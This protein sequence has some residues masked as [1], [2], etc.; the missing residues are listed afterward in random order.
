MEHPLLQGLTQALEIRRLDLT[1]Q[2]I[3]LLVCELHK[4]QNGRLDPASG[5]IKQWDSPSGSS[6][7]PLMPLP[8]R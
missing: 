1:G 6:F 4:G 3:V 2:G 7:P 5:E 8:D